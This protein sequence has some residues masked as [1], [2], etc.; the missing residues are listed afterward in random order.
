MNAAFEVLEDPW[1]ALQNQPRSW[2]ADH[3]DFYVLL[4]ALDAGW[5][6]EPPA[7]VRPREERENGRARKLHFI[8]RRG[9]NTLAL[10]LGDSQRLR[11]FLR[12]EQIEVIP[13]T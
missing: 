7:Q 1:A 6:V 4:S 2:E 13:Y 3:A 11:I 5:K 8:L 9:G 10:S 12:E